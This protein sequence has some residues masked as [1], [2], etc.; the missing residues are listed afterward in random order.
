ML[1]SVACASAS[2]A[3]TASSEL[4]EELP[5]S[6]M[7]F[8]TAIEPQLW[9]GGADQFRLHH[10][11]RRCVAVADR[12][13]LL[14]AQRHAEG[15]DRADGLYRQHDGREPRGLPRGLEEQ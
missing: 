11:G 12:P 3:L 9:P 2:A 14:G 7:I 10:I 5:T 4:V 6:S 13:G 8:V 1:R 15:E